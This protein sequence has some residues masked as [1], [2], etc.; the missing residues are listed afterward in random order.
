MR[1][2]PICESLEH[3]EQ[4]G[5]RPGRG[6]ADASFTLKQVLRKRREHSLESW[7]W[8]QDLVK[9]FD[10]VPREQLWPLL[11]RF[12]TPPKLVRLLQARHAPV[13]VRFEADGVLQAIESIS[14]VFTSVCEAG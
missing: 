9:T 5:F 14:S 4:C 12:G 10:R 1:L 2:T 8:L 7:V 6:C 11:L 13:L 3:E